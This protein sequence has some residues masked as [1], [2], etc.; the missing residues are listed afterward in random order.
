MMVLENWGVIKDRWK[1][2]E[3]AG[4]PSIKGNVYNSRR[5]DG[6]PVQTSAIVATDPVHRTVTTRSGSVYRLGE[7]DPEYAEY[8][9]ETFP[10]TDPFPK[11][12]D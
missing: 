8:V 4:P 5:P 7:I 10:G 11:I 6:H 3:V 9:E 2:P 12:I 1:A